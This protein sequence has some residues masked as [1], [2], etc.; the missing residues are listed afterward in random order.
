M[1]KQDICG[2]LKN[3]FEGIDRFLD[4]KTFSDVFYG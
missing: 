4:S 1:L 3:L 2:H